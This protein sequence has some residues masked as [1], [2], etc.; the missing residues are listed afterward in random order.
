MEWD[1]KCVKCC[2]EHFLVLQQNQAP[3]TTAAKKRTP[4]PE[5]ATMMPLETCSGVT[6]HPPQAIAFGGKDYLCNGELL[7]PFPANC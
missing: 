6:P 3:E 7:P 1:A 2:G 4:R 5:T